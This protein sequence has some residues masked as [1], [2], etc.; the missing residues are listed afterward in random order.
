MKIRWD[1]ICGAAVSIM[2]TL[3]AW[4]QSVVALFGAY[5][6]S[7][8]VTLIHFRE[9]YIGKIWEYRE[10]PVQNKT[11]FLVDQLSIL[12]LGILGPIIHN[13][14]DYTASILLCLLFAMI[15]VVDNCCVH[16][17]KK[18]P[19]HDSSPFLLID[20]YLYTFCFV[21]MRGVNG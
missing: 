5:L 20:A 15:R 12:V 7:A 19:G 13:G 18:L 9:E 1:T 17:N 2:L 8:G 16:S 11:V 21:T 6:F 3:L 4:N 10:S 14:S